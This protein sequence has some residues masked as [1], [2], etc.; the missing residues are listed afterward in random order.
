[1]AVALQLYSLAIEY[2]SKKKT[3]IKPVL[4]WPY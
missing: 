2:L 1:M 4:L 3:G